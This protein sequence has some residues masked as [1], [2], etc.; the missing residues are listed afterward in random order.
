MVSIPEKL[1]GKHGRHTKFIATIEARPML[2]LLVR[3]LSA[4]IIAA[5]AFS[6]CFAI[7]QTRPAGPEAQV[8]AFYSWYI[9]LQ[10][11]SVFPLLNDNIYTY[12]SAK[13]VARLRSDWRNDQLPGD[14]DYFTKVQDYDDRDWR[15]HIATHAA[16]VLGKQALVP[17]TLGSKDKVTVVVLLRKQTR[18]W[19]ITRVDDTNDYP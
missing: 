17:V 9:R 1:T 8:K 13:T 3:A 15:S 5:S 19:K 18:G 4:L 16:V 2:R 12:V 14:G 6:P 10:S 7:A 11:R